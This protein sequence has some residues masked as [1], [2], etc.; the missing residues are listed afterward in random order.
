MTPEERAKL[1]ELH[2]KATPG[3]WVADHLL[4]VATHNA[5]PSLLDALD[6]A[7]QE[8]ARLR[9]GGCARDQRTTQHCAE[10][11][12]LAA[13]NKRM[14]EEVAAYECWMRDVIKTDAC[15]PDGPQCVPTLTQELYDRFLDIRPD[16]KTFQP[17]HA[18]LLAEVATL[19][20]QREA[21]LKAAKAYEKFE[22]ALVTSNEAWQDGAAPFP[23]FTQELY[24]E[25][26]AIQTIRNAA[27][28]LAEGEAKP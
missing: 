7:E 11:A 8:I 4:I 25:W 5:L 15:W 16:G 26:I 2:Q 1:R 21:L 6:A 14:K 24:D 12:T 9:S 10:A 27:I 22:G 13:E 18:T 20:A 17:D 19:K 23:T 28:A 3:E